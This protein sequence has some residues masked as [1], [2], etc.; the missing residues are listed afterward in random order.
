MR[1]LL[2]HLPLLL[3]LLVPLGLLAWLGS[4]ELSRLEDRTNDVLQDE[5]RRFLRAAETKVR[6]EVEAQTQRWLDEEGLGDR[7]GRAD[8][9]LVEVSYVLGQKPLVLEVFVTDARFELVAPRPPKT[10]GPSAPLHSVPLA[11]DSESRELARADWLKSLGDTEGAI[12]CLETYLARTPQKSTEGVIWAAFHLGGLFDKRGDGNRSLDSYFMALTLAEESWP[13]NRTED[14]AAVQLL[15][16]FRRAELMLDLNAMLGLVE[17][18]CADDARYRYADVLADDLLEWVIDKVLAYLDTQPQFRDR[19]DAVTEL[20]QV[21]RTG[22]RFARDYTAFVP[23]R[24]RAQHG[25]EAEANPELVIHHVMSTPQSHSLLALRPARAEERQRYDGA[26]WVGLRLD[27]PALIGKSLAGNPVSPPGNV[28]LTVQA[29][30]GATLLASQVSPPTGGGK[31]EFPPVVSPLGDLEFVAVPIT[32]AASVQRAERNRAILWLTLVFVASFGA[33]LL[34]RSVKRESQL[35]A[36]KVQLLS[37]VTHELKTPLAVIKMYGETIG[38]GRTRDGDQLRKFAGIISNESDRLTVMID[39]ILDFSKMEAGTFRYQRERID[40]GELVDTVTDEFTPH[41]EA[42]GF[43]LESCCAPGL[44][45]DVDPRAM[46]SVVLNLLENAV[47]YTPEGASRH[48]EVALQRRDGSAVLEVR[49]RGMGIPA[50]EAK[51]VFDDFYRASNAG[52]VRGAGLGLSLVDHFARSHQGKIEACPH[53]G[54]GT[55]MRLTLPLAAD[56]A[57]PTPVLDARCT[58]QP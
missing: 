31:L 24:L 51:R 55:I 7:L 11:Q 40:L 49:D 10:H 2:R 9:S 6:L 57:H 28:A 48:I 46:A 26:A 35:A 4:S 14:N 32:D 5:A 43:D 41:A 23:W 36:M 22:R 8:R 29:P 58:P 19:L 34:I 56:P 42:Q 50:A 53:E 44:I 38:L 45:G 1:A 18:L 37:R 25:A 17:G 21:R 12:H 54:G 13:R 47:K 30:S 52:E 27:L 3:T 39:R 33:F 16:T 20:E 15:A